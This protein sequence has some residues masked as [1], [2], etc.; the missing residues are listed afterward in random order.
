MMSLTSSF[1]ASSFWNMRN[2]SVI[3]ARAAFNLATSSHSAS[4][5]NLTQN[6]AI[7]GICSK[8]S[9]CPVVFTLLLRPSSVA[10]TA[11]PRSTEDNLPKPVDPVKPVAPSTHHRA[12]DPAAHLASSLALA[13]SSWKAALACCS[14]AWYS[15]ASPPLISFCDTAHLSPI[16]CLGYFGHDALIGQRL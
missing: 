16:G 15:C 7:L 10:L 9:P 3:A 1:G 4:V 8:P 13:Q 11:F 2:T 5:D 14:P 6:L 12:P